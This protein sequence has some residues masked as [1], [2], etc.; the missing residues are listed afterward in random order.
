MRLILLSILVLL[1][2]APAVSRAQSLGEVAKREEEKQ[3]K[4]KKSGKPP[5]KVKVY[6]EEDLK[7]ARESE[8]GAL[9]VLPENGNLEAGGAAASS[10]DDDEVV[11]GEGRPAGGRRRTEAYWRGRATR[12]RE[13]VDEADG[14]VRDLEARIAALRNDMN[15]VNTQDPNRLQTRDRELQEAMDGLDAARRAADAARKALADLE[16]EARRAGAMPGWVR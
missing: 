6:T 12:A 13:A 15:P 4:K 11:S 2:A 14:K 16:E 3:E 5:A 7:K 8:S 1:V 10:S 9:T